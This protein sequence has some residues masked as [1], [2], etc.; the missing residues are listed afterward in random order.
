MHV[1]LFTVVCVTHIAVACKAFHSQMFWPEILF[2]GVANILDAILQSL[3]SSFSGIDTNWACERAIGL[4]VDCS[5]VQN[6]NM[7][8]SWWERDLRKD[9]PR[10]H[11]E[12]SSIF[13][14]VV[15]V[16]LVLCYPFLWVLN[17]CLKPH[18]CTVH[19]HFPLLLLVVHLAAAKGHIPMTAGWEHFLKLAYMKV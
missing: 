1:G 6:C 12:N 19:T 4:G 16:R 17:F 15:Q 14:V 10:T 7:L 18:T 13:R 2:Q 8:I 5:W 9:F 3:F 11:Q